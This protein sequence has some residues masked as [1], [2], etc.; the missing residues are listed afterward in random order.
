MKP[1]FP[2]FIIFFVAFLV[3][4]LVLISA[5][6]VD[7]IAPG[8]GPP[9][10][11]P[12]DTPVAQVPHAEVQVAAGATIPATAEPAAAQ[13]T[14]PQDGSTLLEDH[15]A[16]CHTVQLLEQSKKTRTEWE[17]TLGRMEGMGVHLSDT[18]KVLLLDY[19]ATADGS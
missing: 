15:C 13:V 3:A 9:T 2:F 6:T 4:V 16:Q 8:T 10:I 5:C 17:N 14:P 11:P 7:V 19:L 1:R 12:A 18:E